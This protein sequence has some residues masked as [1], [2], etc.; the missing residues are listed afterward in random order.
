[1]LAGVLAFNVPRLMN[2][3]GSSAT[4][5]A[6]TAIDPATGL[7]TDGLAP[8]GATATDAGA[9]ATATDAAATGTVVPTAPAVAP[10]TAPAVS[11]ATVLA[12]RRLP[13]KDP[14]VPLLGQVTAAGGAATTEG[15]APFSGTPASKPEPTT[16][17][18]PAIVT[19]SVTGPASGPVLEVGG[20]TTKPAK[21]AKA[22]K[23]VVAP[24][25]V[26]TI[27]VIRANG[28]KQ[29]VA[30]DEFFKVAD[31]WFQLLAVKPKTMK[32]AVVGGGFAGGK[33][34]LT[35][36]RDRPITLVNTATGVEYTLRFNLAT[37][38]VPTTSLAEPKD[39]STAATGAPA[40]T[41]P[42][43]ATEAVPGSEPETVPGFDPTTTIP[44]GS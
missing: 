39:P 18:P 28:K 11:R 7:A 41:E 13:A 2:G 23:P 12:I 22:P 10:A 33:Q 5:A 43:G 34:S 20:G 29:A 8:A 32:I 21:P 25:P 4:P 27:A 26:P 3:G 40:A 38:G 9:Q 14:F 36:R 35:I 16:A 37:T 31:V 30:V 6:E 44:S 24:K 19:P 17:S 1:V 42:A 15:G